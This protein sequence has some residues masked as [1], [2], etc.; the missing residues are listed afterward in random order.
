M[1]LVAMRPVL[2]LAHQ[3]S[4]GD[5]LPVNNPEMTAAWLEAGS[6]MWKED[7]TDAVPAPKAKARPAA[8]EPGKE[9]RTDSGTELQ[10]KVPKTPGRQK[11]KSAGEKA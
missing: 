2:Y 10:G 11:T 3:Y 4:A 7:A 8:A 6:A 1:T 9:G 5:E